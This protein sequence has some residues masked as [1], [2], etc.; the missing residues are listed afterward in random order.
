MTAPIGAPLAPAELDRLLSD[1]LED[2]AG[3]PF[4]W[5]DCTW[6]PADWWLWATGVDPASAARIDF[7][8]E[9]AGRRKLRA[10]GG[11][12]A[13]WDRCLRPLG[14]TRTR[15]PRLGDVGVLRALVGFRRQRPIL[16]RVGGICVG[17]GRWALHSSRGV[18][19]TPADPLAA[20]RLTWPIP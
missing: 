18:S 4:T 17:E 1:F 15:R 5:G 7:A 3:R 16:E 13:Q 11:L 20:W 2:L 19:I 14:A 8:D 9:D 6:A 10:I 12:V